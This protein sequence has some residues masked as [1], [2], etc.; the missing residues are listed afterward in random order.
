MRA[1]IPLLLLSMEERSW[2]EN[3][4]QAGRGRGFLHGCFLS[5]PFLTRNP[6][7]TV[8]GTHFSHVICFKFFILRRVASTRGRHCD[9][10]S[11]A[12]QGVLP[13]PTPA[14]AVAGVHSGFGRTVK[15]GL[16]MSPGSRDARTRGE[17][18]AER[19]A[20]QTGPPPPPPPARPSVPCWRT[21]ALCGRLQ[22]QVL[23]PWI[24]EGN[25]V[26]YEPCCFPLCFLC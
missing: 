21:S 2:R 8:C 25:S 18:E 6:S 3:E 15:S 22:F 12:Q 24:N 14:V 11:S 26:F 20:Q 9:A 1:S 23:Y 13:P 10:A 5:L 7:T 19:G 17:R 16:R 4:W